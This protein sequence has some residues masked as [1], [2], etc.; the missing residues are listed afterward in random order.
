MLMIGVTGYELSLRVGAGELH[1]IL[2]DIA[3]VVQTFVEKS[4][5]R[6]INLLHRQCVLLKSN[7]ML[8]G[9]ISYFKTMVAGYQ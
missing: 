9:E 1:G 8:I 2:T 4:N 5:K 6:P 7:H 3:N